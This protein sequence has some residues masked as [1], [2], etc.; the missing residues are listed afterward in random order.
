MMSKDKIQ[1][2]LKNNGVMLEKIVAN[3]RVYEKTCD[4]LYKSMPI[5]LRW[6]V[7]KKRAKNW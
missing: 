1:E 6:F 5:P 3:P 2:I 4:I 7:G